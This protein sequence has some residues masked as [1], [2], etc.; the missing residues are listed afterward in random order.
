MVNG[1]GGNQGLKQKSIIAERSQLHNRRSRDV[2][3]TRPLP[4]AAEQSTWPHMEGFANQGTYE[5][6]PPSQ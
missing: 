5:I 4:F 3:F 6:F 1:A 2:K